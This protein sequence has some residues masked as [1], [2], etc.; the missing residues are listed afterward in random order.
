MHKT[1][2]GQVQT[3]IAERNL[4]VKRFT[5]RAETDAWLAGLAKELGKDQ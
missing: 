1:I 5:S 4:T 3:K 2:R